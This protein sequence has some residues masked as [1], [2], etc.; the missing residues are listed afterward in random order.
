EIY[1]DN[2]DDRSRSGEC[3]A[4][5]TERGSEEQ[6]SRQPAQLLARLRCISVSDREEHARR[7]RRSKISVSTEIR[8][9][10]RGRREQKIA[11]LWLKEEIMKF[12][13]VIRLL[14]PLILCIQLLLPTGL[15]FGKPLGAHR[16]DSSAVSPSAELTPQMVDGLQSKVKVMED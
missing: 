4:R 5:G 12:S 16:R 7:T 6:V 8:F 13:W 11:S 1:R 15:I 10:H 3:V 14:L 2:E 9:N